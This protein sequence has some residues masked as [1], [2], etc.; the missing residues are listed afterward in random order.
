MFD[1][2]VTIVGNALNTP[3]WRRL[4]TNK[5]MVAKFKVAATSRRYDR[6]SGRWVDGASLRVRVNCWRRLAENVAAWVLSGDPLIVTGRMY[7][8]DWIGDD[9]QRR[10][11]YELDAVAVGHD[12]SR[13]Q[14]RFTRQ[15]QLLSTVSIEDGVEPAAA[16]A[17]QPVAAV[18]GAT[19]AERVD[20][21]DRADQSGVDGSDP[22][23]VGPGDG[24]GDRVGSRAGL[25]AAGLLA[26]LL[27]DHGGEDLSSPGSAGVDR[28]AGADDWVGAL[29]GAASPTGGAGVGVLAAADQR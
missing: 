6:E 1:T 7:T 4:E 2:T 28:S 10:V 21:P 9:G 25:D 29:V 19:R 22:D 5:A 13:G 26:G 18:D 14:G 17:A 27:A 20:L 12:L 16:P 23:L 24:R 15:R 3:E 8:R 11:S